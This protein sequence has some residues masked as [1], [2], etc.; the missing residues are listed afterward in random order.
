MPLFPP[1]GAEN[2]T[3]D[4]RA[5]AKKGREKGGRGGTPSLFSIRKGRK[6]GES[7]PPSAR[8]KNRHSGQSEEK[9][10]GASRLSHLLRGR[11]ENFPAPAGRRKGKY[12]GLLGKK[13][14]KKKKKKKKTYQLSPPVGGGERKRKGEGLTLYLHSYE[15]EG[16][17]QWGRN[18]LSCREKGKKRK[19][20][21]GASSL[22]ISARGEKKRG[23][24][25]KKS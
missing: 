25:K 3:E 9:K 13:K 21:K 20:G 22:S 8:G 16:G 11:R 24:E 2:G 6:G 18:R 19:K 12:A 5:G 10:E 15:K 7:S 23:K 14:G 1:A 4:C 17:R